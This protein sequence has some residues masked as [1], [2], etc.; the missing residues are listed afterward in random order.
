MASCETNG[1]VG[2]RGLHGRF[3]KSQ[4]VLVKKSI[5]SKGQLRVAAWQ[6]LYMAMHTIVQIRFVGEIAKAGCSKT[7]KRSAAYPWGFAFAIAAL[8][9]VDN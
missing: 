9:L 7:L 6:I 5:D 2:S 1:T 3:R 4:P 8:S